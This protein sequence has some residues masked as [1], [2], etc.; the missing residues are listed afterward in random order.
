[1]SLFKRGNKWWAYVWI[2]GVRHNKSTGTSNR[3]Q[4]ET[5]ER[6]FH[7]EL[8]EVRQRLPQLKPTMTFGELAALFIGSG[9][10]NAVEYVRFMTMVVSQIAHVA[11]HGE[12]RGILKRIDE[13]N[14][15]RFT[16]GWI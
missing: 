7:D 15:C 16:K 6:Q 2:D 11:P 5:I 10:G 1:M 13:F 8:N 4:A 12:S 14:Y 3:R 9:M